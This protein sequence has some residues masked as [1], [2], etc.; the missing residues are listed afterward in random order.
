MSMKISQVII[1]FASEYID[2]GKTIE[3]KQDHLNAACIAW[4]IA[5]LPAYKRQIALND[6]L[7]QYQVRNPHETDVGHI[8][9]DMELLIQQKLERFPHIKTSIVQARIR[10]SGDTYRIAVKALPEQQDTINSSS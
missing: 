8:K 3:K 6:F 7:T 5:I 4:N 1:E 2:L 10:D 9:H